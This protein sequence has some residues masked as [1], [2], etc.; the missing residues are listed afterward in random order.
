M[1]RLRSIAIGALVAVAIALTALTWRIVFADPGVV[2]GLI[3]GAAVLG[4]AIAVVGGPRFRPGIALAITALVGLAML[5]VGEPRE[6]ATTGLLIG[7][8]P[9]FLAIPV[10]ASLGGS[11]LATNMLIRRSVAPLAVG[12][13]GL[14]HS[15]AAAYTVSFGSPPF[16]ALLGSVLAVVVALGL[17][18]TALD[19][20]D[21]H[22]E[23]EASGL[24]TW[25]PRLAVGGSALLVGSALLWVTS[26]ADSFDLR[27]RINPPVEI[28][29]AS[30]PLSLLKS[31]L[32]DEANNE[33]FT[34]TVTGLGP[35]DSIER[36][37]AAILDQ[38]DGAVWSA[39]GQY[40]PAGAELPQ[41]AQ[42]NQQ[43]TP[44]VAQLLELSADYP[45]LS[46]PT[47]GSL[48]TIE[49]GD[50][51]WDPVSGSLVAVGASSD[52]LSYESTAALGYQF[53]PDTGPTELAKGPAAGLTNLPPEI[54]ASDSVRET[55]TTF[56]EPVRQ[57]NPGDA[58]AQLLGFEAALR[59][60]RFG[61][62]EE[63]P[64]GHSLAK[65]ATYL[66]GDENGRSAGFEEQS[67]AAFAVLARVID[68]PSRVVVG[69]EPA[70]PITADQ[71]E[72]RL[73]STQVV[74]WPEVWLEGVGWVAFDPTDEENLTN[75][76]ASKPPVSSDQG[77]DRSAAA[78]PEFDPPDALIEDPPEDED[79]ATRQWWLWLLVP[80]APIL[81][82]ALVSAA[83]RLRRG[84]RRS[85]S[86]PAESIL[87]AWRETEDRLVDAGQPV[88]DSR[89][90]I[91]LR[92]SLDLTR[93]EEGTV[94]IASLTDLATDV[95][96]ALYSPDTPPAEA[97]TH[98][99]ESAQTS[100]DE[101]GRDWSP[102]TK[103]KAAANPRSF[104]RN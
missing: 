1:N 55:F 41:A 32:V 80:L 52:P 70:E 85:A 78:A 18:T 47:V 63:A 87:G 97:A 67:A 23:S 34:I 5:F 27:N 91:D 38:Y 76:A 77:D 98:A 57:E 16:A 17:S 95:D 43:A 84:G 36:I 100:L 20:D 81:Y 28:L 37:P 25:L 12:V 102:L 104:F 73:V 86:D 90:V 103:L 31:G 15:V 22:V 14:V 24:A 42:A 99:W 3:A 72:A 62:N 94:L 44:E 19:N 88:P 35:D 68:A 39:S 50:L 49:S 48:Q 54:T 26:G 66:A 10:G 65:L 46:V 96:L 69:Y 6:L 79:S 71:P 74:A 21:E 13:I 59:G 61:Y 56:V 53:R 89:R 2:G 93:Q 92:D 33:V 7:S 45:F 9:E 58:W 4:A 64:G 11:L 83:K 40:V 60:E 101:I 8:R 51:L 82:L 29:D 75:D 30:S